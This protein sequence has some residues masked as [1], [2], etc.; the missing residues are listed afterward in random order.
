M[1]NLEEI[2]T[3][4]RDLI[5]PQIPAVSCGSNCLECG[6]YAHAS[7]E[8]AYLYLLTHPKR[9]LHKIGIG[10]V[11]KDKGQIQNLINE[12]WLVHGI[13]H[14]RDKRRTFNWEREIFRQLEVKSSSLQS[15]EAG[16]M[17]RRDRSW[18]ESV[19]AQFISVSALALQI[20]KIVKDRNE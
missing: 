5:N 18:V 14:D 2:C 11:G 3:Q 19:S 7:D 8:P 6:R 15:D 12:G 9:K 16:L 13:W 17:G 1:D 20:S 10:T 4:C